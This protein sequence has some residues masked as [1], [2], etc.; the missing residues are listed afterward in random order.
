MENGT[1]WKNNYNRV[2]SIVTRE[3]ELIGWYMHWDANT[4]RVAK[5]EASKIHLTR[6]IEGDIL[7]LGN[8]KFQKSFEMVPITYATKLN[9]KLKWSEV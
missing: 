5:L 1:K 4:F 3:G 8:V 9:N 2:A 6:M 7:T